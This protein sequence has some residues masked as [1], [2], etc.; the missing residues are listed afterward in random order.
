LAVR[1]C[2]SK[3]GSRIFLTPNLMSVESG[4]PPAFDKPRINE[5]ELINA[6]TKTDTVMYILPK[7]V[8]VE[9]TPEIIKFDSKFGSY[10]ADTQVKNGKLLYIRKFVRNRGNFPATSY[11]ELVDFYK[12]IT[13]ADRTQVVMKF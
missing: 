10:Y 11:V 7:N 6:Y 13:K 8:S 4:V 3:S 12:K 9:F 2:A 1:K 5:V